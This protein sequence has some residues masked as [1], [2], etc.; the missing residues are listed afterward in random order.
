M[1][2][3]EG[4]GDK[5]ALYQVIIDDLMQRIN[6]HAYAAN[7]PLCTEKQLMD[8]YQ[9]SR[10]TAKR[11]I[12]EL[13]SRGI[14][15]R[16]RGAGSFVSAG[17]AAG[18]SAGQS[19]QF[20]LVLPFD[21]SKGGISGVFQAANRTLEQH[22]C[23]LSITITGD[24]AGARGREVLQKLALQDIAGIAYYPK[25]GNAHPDLLRRYVQQNKPVVVLDVACD[26][27]DV[28]VVV[29]DHFEGG[30]L[31]T[32][33]LIA[34]GHQKIAYVSGVH[35][36]ARSSVRDRYAGFAAAAGEAGIACGADCLRVLP[37]GGLQQSIATLVRE[38]F[39]AVETENDEL[40][41]QVFLACKELGILVPEQLSLCG[42][43]HSEWSEMAPGGITTIAQDFSAI[44]RHTARLLLGQG[45]GANGVDQ[46]T[47]PV[48]LVVRG[49]TAPPAEKS[50]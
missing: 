4:Q 10:I 36:N 46:I 50:R 39:T 44:G 41:F 3:P 31:L 22:G 7:K 30:R 23:Y 14:L 40:A 18:R 2:T 43:D 38:G 26:C 47:V 9:V 17:A 6:S 28:G 29:S 49:S 1:K 20:A 32:E 33:H 35:P 19:R 11:A 25:T 48:R 16:R 12:T 21:V 15:Y 8:Q 45:S 37:P 24:G 13:E 34:L 42:F 5:R 27:P